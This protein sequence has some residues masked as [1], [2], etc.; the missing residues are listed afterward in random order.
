MKE[1]QEIP[2]ILV[3]PFLAT[4]RTLIDVQKGQ[5]ILRVQDE[6]V[7]FNVLKPLKHLH[8]VKN[9]MRVDVMDG[10]IKEILQTTTPQDPLEACLIGTPNSENLNIIECVNQLEAPTS[11]FIK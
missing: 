8:D 1:D 7:T 10:C 9:C 3:R 5:L 6:E 2:I 11:I 4:G